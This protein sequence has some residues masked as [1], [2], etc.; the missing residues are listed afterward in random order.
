MEPSG[1]SNSS[2]PD[3]A[4]LAW[5]GVRTCGGLDRRGR[6]VR[7]ARIARDV[8]VDRLL[9]RLVGLPHPL[10]V[11]EAL[12]DRIDEVLGLAQPL[13]PVPVLP[14]A[15]LPL[16]EVDPVFLEPVLQIVRN[17]DLAVR[18]RV[19]RSARLVAGIVLVGPAGG[20]G[21][22][23]DRGDRGHSERRGTRAACAPPTD[24]GNWS[25]ESHVVIPLGLRNSRLLY[26]TS[27]TLRAICSERPADI[28]NTVRA[29]R[30]APTMPV[31]MGTVRSRAMVPPPQ[32]S[33]DLPVIHRDRRR[34]YVRGTRGQRSSP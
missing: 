18:G 34:W 14:L 3:S 11:P 22:R 6:R 7:H 31:P 9:R 2:F 28:R 27:A 20:G 32:G 13:V 12:D 26:C 8:I 25:N 19:G 10:R 29:F 21:E 15:V 17:G 1:L 16:V 5:Y 24:G 30:A 4:A 33:S 23:E